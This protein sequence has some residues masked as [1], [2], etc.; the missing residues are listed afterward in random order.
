VA[1]L[2]I[3]VPAFNEA[4]RLPA[5]LDAVAQ[6]RAI[7]AFDVECVVVDDGSADG[8][9]ESIPDQGWITVIRHETN[10]G[11]GHAVR[12]G[13]LAARGDCVLTMDADLATPLEEFDALSKAIDSGFDVA[14]G[15]R[16]LRESQLLVRQPVLREM[17]GRAFNTV[18]RLLA[19]PDIHD[20]QCGFKLF[21]RRAAREIFERCELDG[22]GYDVESLF[23]AKKLG[24]R[25]KEIPVRWRHC[26]GA[27]AFG[28]PWAYL[29]HGLRMLRDVVR[30]RS[31]HGWVR[32]V[33]TEAAAPKS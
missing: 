25:V 3:V 1:S 33:G 32:P 4:R 27:A 20:T 14:I 17:A 22:F 8:T 10:H 2:S 11:K 31:L 21:T 18:V 29:R 19:V 23:L 26:E 13:V 9:S 6:W 7:A 24:F 30:V 16:P 5:T 12:A 15:S 28:T